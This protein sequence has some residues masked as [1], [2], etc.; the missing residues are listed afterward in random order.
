MT[1][2]FFFDHQLLMTV[3]IRIGVCIHICIYT[4]RCVY[5][6]NVY[7]TYSHTHTHTQNLQD[8]LKTQRFTSQIFYINML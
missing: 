6:Q 7:D 3:C 5:I 1:I 8:G 2:N 4:Y